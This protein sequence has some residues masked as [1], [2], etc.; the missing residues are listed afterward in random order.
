MNNVLIL[1]ALI[2][3]LMGVLCGGFIVFLLFTVRKRISAS[4][5]ANTHTLAGQMGTVEIPFDYHAKGKI[6][7]FLDNSTKELIAF[8]DPP[9]A[10]NKGDQVLIVQVKDAQ[11]WVVP[12]NLFE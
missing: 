6:S 4:S 9:N 2:A 12:G 5:L 1:V 10:F 11:A 7:V 8:T 3:V